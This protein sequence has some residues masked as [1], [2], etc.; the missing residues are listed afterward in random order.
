MGDVRKKASEKIFSR[1]PDAVAM[2]DGFFVFGLL[3]RPLETKA[4]INESKS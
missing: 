3:V 1:E 4:R 2:I